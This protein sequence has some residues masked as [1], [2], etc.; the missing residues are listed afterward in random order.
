M[1]HL[2]PK[3]KSQGGNNDAINGVGTKF[4]PEETNADKKQY[5]V[6]D[7]TH[8]TDGEVD[9]QG[10]VDDRADTADAT[11]HDGSRKHHR[12]PCKGVDEDTQRD[13]QVGNDDL[14]FFLEN[15]HNY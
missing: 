5:G 2:L 10:I 9:A 4:G 11:T 12:R 14:V 3:D 8:N 15:L 7:E 6:D 13:D 1:E